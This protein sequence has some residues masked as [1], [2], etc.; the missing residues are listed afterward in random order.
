MAPHAAA[1]TPHRDT[2]RPRYDRPHARVCFGGRRQA[3]MRTGDE[4][5]SGRTDVTTETRPSA[6]ARRSGASFGSRGTAPESGRGAT[7]ERRGTAPSAGPGSRESASGSR[8]RA[9][10]SRGRASGSRESASRSR[11]GASGR[12]G[13]GSGTKVAAPRARTGAATRLSAAARQAV[14]ARPHARPALRR[15]AGGPQGSVRSARRQLARVGGRDHESRTHFVFLVVG[16][17]GGTLL[18]L[19][20]INTVLASG[21]FQITGLEQG[22]VTLAQQEQTLRAQIAA[23]K[24]PASLARRARQLGMVEPPLLHFLK[25]ATGR[26]DSRS[27]RRSGAPPGYGST[28]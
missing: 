22:N 9:S 18:C 17:L 28:P 4:T 16:L 27:P 21:S 14:P 8:G 26:I 20:L 7:S 19:L 15:G 3:R 12:R 23:A 25:L 11:G 10:G 5:V 1:R 24:S 2:G 6:P 13:T